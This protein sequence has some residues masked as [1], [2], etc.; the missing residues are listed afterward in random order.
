MLKQPKLLLPPVSLW[1]HLLCHWALSRAH[2]NL[3]ATNRGASDDHLHVVKCIDYHR[4]CIKEART[5]LKA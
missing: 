2:D 3:I 1:W 5:Q 4:N